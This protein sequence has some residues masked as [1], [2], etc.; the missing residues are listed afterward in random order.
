MMIVMMF[1]DC[2]SKG[3]PEGA[4]GENISE[5]ASMDDFI[6]ELE[7]RENVFRIRSWLR[8]ETLYGDSIRSMRRWMVI[9][10]YLFF[11]GLWKGCIDDRNK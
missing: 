5:T 7:G 1:S 4:S 6:T 3:N 10:E 11:C 9:R 8:S 2:V